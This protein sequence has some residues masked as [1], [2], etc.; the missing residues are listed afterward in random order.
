MHIRRLHITL[1]NRLTYEQNE[2]LSLSEVISLG[3]RKVR[4]RTV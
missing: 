1:R 4:K 2:E 3:R